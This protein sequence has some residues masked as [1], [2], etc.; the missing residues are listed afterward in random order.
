MNASS[1]TLYLEPGAERAQMLIS[2]GITQGYYGKRLVF[3]IVLN[4]YAFSLRCE[5]LG[6]G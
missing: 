6:G 1:D 2:V 5:N 4:L 3:I